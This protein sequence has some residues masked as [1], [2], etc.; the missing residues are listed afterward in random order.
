MPLQQAVISFASSGMKWQLLYRH[1]L[2]TVH[3]VE[4]KLITVW[5]QLADIRPE[6]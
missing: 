3:T 4:Q 1:S 6:S 5:K 2:V